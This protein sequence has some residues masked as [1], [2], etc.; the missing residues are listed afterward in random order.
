MM[1]QDPLDGAAF[2]VE[3]PNVEV[4]VVKTPNPYFSGCQPV[5]ILHNSSDATLYHV[6]SSIKTQ[7]QHIG[8]GNLALKVGGNRVTW[9]DWEL[10]SL[11]AWP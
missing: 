7:H 9:R 11:S 8:M 2:P 4:S 1:P 3:V 6:Q 10:D 5:H